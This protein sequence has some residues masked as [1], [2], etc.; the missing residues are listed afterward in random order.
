MFEGSKIDGEET[1]VEKAGSLPTDLAPKAGFV[2]G[3][4][5]V[6]KAMK[7]REQDCFEEVPILGATSEQ[8]TK[9]EFFTAGFVDIDDGEIAL[10]GSGDVEAE[11]EGIFDW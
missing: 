3:G 1:T 9:P 11:T 2:T 10:A 8:A 4:L 5:D 7:E 6:R